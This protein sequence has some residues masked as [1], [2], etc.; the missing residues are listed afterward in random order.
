MLD[1][2]RLLAYFN[3]H[4]VKLTFLKIRTRLASNK[5]K[6][7]LQILVYRSAFAVVGDS[8]FLSCTVTSKC[9]LNETIF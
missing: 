8:H 3:G 6:I 5:I 2:S 7:M 1:F 9:I 4:F